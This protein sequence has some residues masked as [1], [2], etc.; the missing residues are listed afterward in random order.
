MSLFGRK[1]EKNAPTIQL[2][3]FEPVL[4]CSICSGEQVLCAR[5]RQTG[6][7]HELMLIRSFGELKDF[8][9]ANGIEPESV[10]KIY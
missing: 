10:R 7:I 8:C 5:D 1:K 3:Q 9:D 4:R 2:D 6:A